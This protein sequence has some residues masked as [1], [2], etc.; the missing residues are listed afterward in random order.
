MLDEL[1]EKAKEDNLTQQA[2]KIQETL[3]KLEQA[4]NKEEMKKALDE[5]GLDDFAKDMVDK[6]GNE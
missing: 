3:E 5:S 2:E 4:Q 1:I 6:V